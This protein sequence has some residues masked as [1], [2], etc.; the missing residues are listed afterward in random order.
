MTNRIYNF[1]YYYLH[2]KPAIK[3]NC[4]IGWNNS[5]IFRVQNCQFVLFDTVIN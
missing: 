1:S 2:A 4:L 5:N 3:Q